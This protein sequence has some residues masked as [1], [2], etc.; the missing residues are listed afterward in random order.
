MEK[1]YSCKK[2]SKLTNPTLQLDEGQTTYVPTPYAKL[3]LCKECYDQ[4]TFLSMYHI[5]VGELFFQKRIFNVSPSMG[6][7]SEAERIYTFTNKEKEAQLYKDR[8]FAEE[9]AKEMGGHTERILVP[10]EQYLNE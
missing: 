2:C 7:F 6:S 4:T 5:K 1:Y 10:V 3:E 8:A 9:L